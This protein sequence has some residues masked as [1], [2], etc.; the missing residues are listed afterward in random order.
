[1]CFV[2]LYDRKPE[3]IGPAQHSDKFGELVCSNSLKA[4]RVENASGLLKEEM[5][6]LDSLILSCAQ[7]TNVP[8]GG[9]L[10]VDREAFAAEVTRRIRSMPGIETVCE[11]VSRIPVEQPCIV[12]SGPLTDGEL[13]A[14]IA[15]V[16]C[17]EQC[18]F[19]DASAPLIAA[20]SIDFGIAFRSARYD[21]GGDYVNCP[22]DEDQYRAFYEQLIAAETVPLRENEPLALF[23]GCM[24]VEAMAKRGYRTLAFGM[25]K[26]VGLIDP[27]SGKRPFAVLQ[28]R[29]DNAQGT[30]YN[31]VGFQTNLKFPEQKRI[32]SMI[33]GLSKA[34]FLRY[35][36]MHRNTFINGPRHLNRNYQCREHPMLF[37][38]G[39][40]T[41]V[42]GY[43]E[44]ASSGL[45]AGL[46]AAALLAGQPMP[47][48]SRRTAIG[49]LCHYVGH[50]NGP[51]YQP[52]NI[53][54]GIIEPLTTRI[55]NKQQRYS[56]VARRA[57][58]EIAAGFA[59][60]SAR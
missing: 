35:G 14:D 26:P 27:R 25:L 21:R 55:R 53:N 4:Q 44:S 6:L 54:F 24:P 47:D 52:M 7:A 59:G 60:Q 57:L 10:A 51:D 40:I 41:G 36:V 49:A 17:E 34:E 12:A 15:R 38:A 48:F 42:E 16:L 39:Q 13:A 3:K 18:Y 20:D 29:Q 58:E 56:E 19:Y 23:E 28:L 8:A 46:S 22:M 37:F 11:E 32:F 31:M 43:V 30:V 9:A 2:K 1:G 45:V 33:P 50:Y 5:R